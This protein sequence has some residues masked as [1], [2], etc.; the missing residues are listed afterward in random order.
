M[1]FFK[2]VLSMIILLGVLNFILVTEIELLL[3]LV[4]F[5]KANIVCFTVNS[6]AQWSHMRGV[7]FLSRYPCVMFV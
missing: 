3:D 2:H 7:I 4:A 5:C 6:V 1:I